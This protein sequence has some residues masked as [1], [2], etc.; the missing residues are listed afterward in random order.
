MKFYQETTD[1][2]VPNHIYLLSTD[3]SR[4]YGYMK[5]GSAEPEVFRKPYR[6]D[7][8]GRTFREVPELGELDLNNLKSEARWEVSG[9]RGNTY[10]VEKVDG[11]LRCSCPGYLYHGQCRHVNEI[12]TQG[13]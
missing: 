12:A 3:K 4:A 11:V 8:R 10:I 13:E 1:W 2:A 9:S 5:A 7:A 6:F